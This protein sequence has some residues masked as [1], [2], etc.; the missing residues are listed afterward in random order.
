[1]AGMIDKVRKIIGDL[2]GEIEQEIEDRR[3]EFHYRLEKGRVVFEQGVAARHRLL[4]M[5]LLNFLHASKILAILTAPIIYS[6]II[7]LVLLDIF[8]TVFQLVCFPVYKI[9]RVKR[10]EYV[11]MDRK[12]LEYLNVI[13]KLNC[14]Y[15][16]YGNGVI[17]YA[18]EVASRTEWFWCPIKH[19]RK[20][21]GSHE[22]YLDFIEYGD[23]D[24]YRGKL[25][26]V[27]EKCRACEVGCA[28]SA[29]KG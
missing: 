20:V 14:I 29:P 22:H 18:R 9:P 10:G 28:A 15:C 24:D 19:A 8:I 21:K 3:Q 7:P 16:E 6:V 27:R 12:Y 2:Q 11:V 26:G 1:M 17:A 25:K 4:R 5:K 23:G 13:E